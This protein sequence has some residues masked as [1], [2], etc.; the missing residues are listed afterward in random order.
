MTRLVSS[1]TSMSGTVRLDESIM[2]Y[3]I[4]CAVA[5]VVWLDT[6]MPSGVLCE[7]HLT[8]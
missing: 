7:R 6:C 2:G 8:G 4:G 3:T 1:S 5:S